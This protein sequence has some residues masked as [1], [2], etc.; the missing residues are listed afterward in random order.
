MHNSVEGSTE[1]VMRHYV[2][3]ELINPTDIGRKY[4]GMVL[5]PNLNRGSMQT[6]NA[7]FDGLADK[8]STLGINDGIGW[9]IILDIPNKQFLFVV[10]Q[11]VDRS[12]NQL[13]VPP[14]KFSTEFETLKSMSYAESKID[15]KNVAIVAGQGEGIERRIVTVGNAVG[16]DR[17]ELF[18][19]ARDVSEETEGDNPTQRPD[20]DVIADLEK[21]GE[22][23][24]NECTQTV[25]CE[26]QALQSRNLKF[27]RDYFLGDI[28]TQQNK[29][30]GIEMDARITSVKEVVE[31][32]KTDVELTFDNDRPTLISKIKNEMAGIKKE[33]QK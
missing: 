16:R 23:K 2:N 13:I 27:E 20:A 30:W 5:S 8:L 25:Y 19:D 22:E 33:L 3:T 6:V 26:G 21:R 31:P 17:Y 15:Y 11:G 14:A 12:A 28:V 24:L 1:S 9:D 7:R 29:G 4:P 18:V 10:T 32:G